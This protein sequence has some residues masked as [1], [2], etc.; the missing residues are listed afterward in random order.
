MGELGITEEDGHTLIVRRKTGINRFK[1]FEHN[2]FFDPMP[3][4]NGFHVKIQY[5][6]NA[7]LS[8][9]DSPTQRRSK[10]FE[11]DL[12]CSPNV[13][14][15]EIKSYVL[16][17][18]PREFRDSDKFSVDAFDLYSNLV[19]DDFSVQTDTT[20][21][22]KG[23]VSGGCG[24]FG[25]TLLRDVWSSDPTR[26]SILSD[27][28]ITDF[29]FTI[30]VRP[31][32]V[33]A[34]RKALTVSSQHSSLT[35][36]A[37][38]GRRFKQMFAA[39]GYKMIRPELS[40]DNNQKHSSIGLSRQ[41]GDWQQH[42]HDVLYAHREQCPGFENE[43]VDYDKYLFVPDVKLC[44]FPTDSIDEW[45]GTLVFFSDE[46]TLA[47]YDPVPGRTVKL[48][49]LPKGQRKEMEGRRYSWEFNDFADDSDVESD[50]GTWRVSFDSLTD[51]S[52]ESSGEFFDCETE[53][54]P[55]EGADFVGSREP[56]AV[57]EPESKSERDPEIDEGEE[58]G[59]LGELPGSQQPAVETSSSFD[60]RRVPSK[61]G[62]SSEKTSRPPPLRHRDSSAKVVSREKRRLRRLLR[63]VEGKKRVK[64]N[65]VDQVVS[66][67]GECD[68]TTV[69][70]NG[71]HYVIHGNGRA[72]RTV[73]RP[74]GG[75]SGTPGHAVI[76]IILNLLEPDP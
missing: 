52:S 43:T 70:R 35:T 1:Q 54:I 75:R 73:V 13:K 61:T 10:S 2:L 74:H 26:D 64:A 36:K 24:G 31:K 45:T 34:S 51:T 53:A 66:A 68:G 47:H 11:R 63:K 16:S 67:C 3:W 12:A 25:L 58:N 49:L 60:H 38:T 7:L 5:D 37:A 8:V 14:I 50:D 32:V 20:S 18:L 69:N 4:E 56:P 65:L 17:T 39:L 48:V 57:S 6:V 42:V 27:Y 22:D 72:P 41:I 21:E 19:K 71:S 33:M 23:S 46:L 9:I 40:Q 28:D 55:R 29:G 76:D 44:Y 62:S 15:K 59:E 30:I